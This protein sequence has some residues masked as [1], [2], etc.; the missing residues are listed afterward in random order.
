MEDVVATVNCETCGNDFEV[1]ARNYEKVV[2]E[3][4]PVLCAACFE[5][6][7]DEQNRPVAPERR[8]FEYMIVW[9]GE[10]SEIETDNEIIAFTLYGQDGWELV[11]IVN[12]K[13][14]FKREY[15]KGLN[16]EK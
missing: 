9:T 5:K 16:S 13:A 10:W 12:N 1:L 6:I 15:V 4:M 3:D 2:Q 14:Y 7:M 11:Q 8:K